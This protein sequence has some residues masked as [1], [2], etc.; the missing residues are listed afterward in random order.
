MFDEFSL[1]IYLSFI[2]FYP[3][4]FKRVSIEEISKCE[5]KNIYF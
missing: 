2:Y 5:I 4:D 3:D 1:N